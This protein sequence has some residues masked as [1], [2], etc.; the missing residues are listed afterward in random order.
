MLKISDAVLEILRSDEVAQ[1]ALRL[2]LLNLSAYATR[3]QPMVER[4]TWKEVKV[5]TIVVTLSRLVEA[6]R[7]LPALHSKVVFDELTIKSPLVDITYEKTQANTQLLRSFQQSVA[8]SESHFVM[9]TQG[10]REITIIVPSELQEKVIAHFNQT[11]KSV[12]ENLVG[13]TVS[14]SEEYL[15]QPNFIYSALAALA[16]ERINL[17]EIV[18]TY[19]ELSMIIDKTD[20]DT[21]IRV[22][23]PMVGR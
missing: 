14:F 7:A 18:S 8:G 12:Y 2:G 15:E 9:V 11:P 6:V 16:G 13:I 3:I 20:M 22:L 5:A 21:A 10:T 23:Q 17:R 1:E 4:K 19:T